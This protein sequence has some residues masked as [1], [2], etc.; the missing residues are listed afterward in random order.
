MGAGIVC[1]Y[2]LIAAAMA[3]T[4]RPWFDEAA[5]ANPALDLVTRGSM[6]A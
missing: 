6:E 2:L 5:F 4:K 1:L 3:A